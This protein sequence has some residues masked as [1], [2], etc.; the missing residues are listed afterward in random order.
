M[1]LPLSGMLQF[2]WLALTFGQVSGFT[3]CQREAPLVKFLIED[4]KLNELFT[5]R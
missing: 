4:V 2:F 3:P 1:P 5:E